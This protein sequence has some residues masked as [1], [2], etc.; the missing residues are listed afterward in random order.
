M[1][2]VLMLLPSLTVPA[3]GAPVPTASRGG[4][5]WLPTWVMADAV[6]A[7]RANADLFEQVSPFW[8]DATSCTRVTPRQGGGDRSVVSALRERGL[9]V[10]PTVTATGLSPAA[11]VHCLG[12][13]TRRRAH[14]TLLVELAVSGGYD[15]LDVNYEH[16]ALTTDPAVARRVRGAFTRF[17]ADLCPA[18]RGVG[19]QCSVTVMPRTSARFTVWR[20]KLMPAVYAYKA[21][22]V[23]AD[24]IRVM[25]YDQ[26]ALKHGP[27]PIAGLPWVRRVVDYAVATMPR[28]KVRLGVPTYGRDFSRGSSVSLTR[29]AATELAARRGLRPRWDSLQAEATF[30]YRQAGVRHT[31][32][33]SSPRAVT[34]R[35]R[36][37]QRRGLAGVVYWAAGL[38]PRGTW[39]AVRA[40]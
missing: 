40:G 20:G 21:L 6:A 32:W 22:A 24:E 33:F 8:F 31:V 27:G 13:D 10:V 2:L 34:V 38:E 26:H 9:R 39:A 12:D 4:A 17:V 28:R 23:A 30:T 16:L 14:V 36:L 11:A 25:A 15:G 18:L 37:A 1:V 19:K 29:N 35:T 5:A 3:S 7:V